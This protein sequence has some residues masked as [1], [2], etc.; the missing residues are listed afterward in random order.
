MADTL[1]FYQAPITNTTGQGFSD[2]NKI[3]PKPN[4]RFKSSLNLESVGEEKTSIS[5]GGGDPS[6]DLS[7]FYISNNNGAPP[8]YGFTQ[9]Q[10]T[11]SGHKIILDDTPESERVVI[12]HR[13]GAG[14]ELK[15]DGSIKVRSKN[16]MAIS[17]DANGAIIV[18]GDLKIS[19]KNLTVD[20]SGDFDL[21]VAGDWNVN[22]AG[23]KKEKISGSH[24][25]D[26][27]KNR[28]ETVGQDRIRNV[29]GS[30]TVTILKNSITNVK[31]NSSFTIGGAMTNSVKGNYKNTSMAEY[32]VS[33]PSV[34]LSAADLTVAGVAGTI[35]GQ[36]MVYYGAN[37]HIDR[38]DNTFM[39]TT[40]VEGDLN[41]TAASSVNSNQAASIGGGGGAS[42]ASASVTQINTTRVTQD[43]MKKILSFS[44]RGVGQ[45]SIDEGNGILNK[46]DRTVKMGGISNKKLSVAEVRTKL[47]DPANQVNANFLKSII[48]DNSLSRKYLDKVPPG[49]GRSYAGKGT[50]AFADPGAVLDNSGG[51]FSRFFAAE[52]SS[53]KG[54][55]IDPRYDP[56]SK[57]VSN[58]KDIN[59]KT[60]VGKGIPISTFFSGRGG[61]TNLGHIGTIEE[62]KTLAR[63]LV[64]QADVIKFI[65]SDE[66][67][68]RDF[69][70]VV[71]EGIYKPHSGETL[72][73][74]SILDLATKGIAIT[75]EIYDEDNNLY[76]EVSYELAEFLADSLP[77]YD[78]IILH[79]DKFDPNS[80]KMHSQVT[81]VMPEVDE[82]FEPVNGKPG[83]DLETYYNLERQS[84]TDLVE[85][86]P[87]GTP[88]LPPI[89]VSSSLDDII[90]YNLGAIRNKRIKPT[91]ERVLATAARKAKIDKVVIVSGKQ[92]GITGERVGSMRH[93]TGLAADL[94]LIRDGNVLTLDTQLGRKYIAEF[95]KQASAL[96]VAAGGMSTD[97]M[98]NRTMHLDMLGTHLGNGKYDSTRKVTWKSDSWFTNALKNN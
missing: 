71:A 11:I 4:Y 89:G 58:V 37:A 98:G 80:S 97:Y 34:S 6:I 28:R 63:Q 64:L 31:Q 72:T 27:T 10:E 56:N 81:V 90:E 41:G 21:N 82:N 46:I 14:V 70:I 45:V 52:R 2:P 22:V 96:G 18:D 54:I 87:Y 69:R 68:F 77:V 15:E 88:E 16:N 48:A 93:D 85:I 13:T 30:E 66:Y 26:I 62:R 53:F 38:I 61:A 7:E 40:L 3:Y 39:K 47:K 9:T 75:Y 51:G 12:K 24:R 60:F 94:Y 67:R 84:N 65:R 8:L 49:I 78:K 5:L 73:P 1:D 43:L 42:V 17:I 32:I 36:S 50:V 95:V 55:T 23:D 74:G 29:I 92:P 86:D 25:S 83:F 33:A 44:S 57:P 76:P 91:F 79:Y 59:G 20:V 35:G 19:S